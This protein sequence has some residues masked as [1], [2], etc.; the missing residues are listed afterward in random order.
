MVFIAEP[1]ARRLATSCF[2]SVNLRYF[3]LAA[4]DQLCESLPLPFLV[5]CALPLAP[6]PLSGLASLGVSSSESE[7]EP[8]E[9]SMM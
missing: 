2:S 5:R 9:E 4:V 8:E 6:L 1:L 3:L 7:I